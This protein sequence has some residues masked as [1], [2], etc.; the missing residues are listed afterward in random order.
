MM[1]CNNRE[2]HS[3]I[4]HDRAGRGESHRT[5][6]LANRLRTCGHCTR[7]WCT[8]E[9]QCSHPK[10]APRCMSGGQLTCAPPWRTTSQTKVGGQPINWSQIYRAVVPSPLAHRLAFGQ[11]RTAPSEEGTTIKRCSGLNTPEEGS[12]SKLA[13]FWA[14]AVSLSHLDAGPASNTTSNTSTQYRMHL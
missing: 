13:G 1:T 5:L 8:V 7:M 3:G 10:R 9:R 11:A 2:I 6:A 4:I 14:L 12:A